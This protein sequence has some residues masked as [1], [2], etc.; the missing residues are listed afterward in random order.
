MDRSEPM[1]PTR[2]DASSL[3]ET[4]FGSVHRTSGGVLD[5][6]FGGHSLQFEEAD[7]GCIR[8]SVVSLAVGAWDY[9]TPCRWQLR[10]QPAPDQPV[11]VLR[12]CEVFRL[13]ELLDGAATMLEL[14]QILDEAQIDGAPGDGRR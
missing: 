13:K 7:L 9:E 2:L 14:E 6:T 5:V 1:T 4:D 3:Y 12:T 10:I 11:M 8:A